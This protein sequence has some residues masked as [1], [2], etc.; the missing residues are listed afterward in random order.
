MFPALITFFLKRPFGMCG[1]SYSG[2]RNIPAVLD[3]VGAWHPCCGQQ[4]LTFCLEE[5]ALAPLV[6]NEQNL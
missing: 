5:R 3:R 2:P 4:G 1:T 6:G